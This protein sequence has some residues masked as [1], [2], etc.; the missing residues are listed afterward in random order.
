M[1]SLCLKRRFNAGVKKDPALREL[2][3]IASEPIGYAERGRIVG[4]S[5]GDQRDG[6]ARV[7]AV[8]AAT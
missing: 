1:G 4:A 3:P 8:F 5:H 6:V 2:R 7:A